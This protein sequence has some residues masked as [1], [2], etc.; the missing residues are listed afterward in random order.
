MDV[1]YWE[2]LSCDAVNYSI[3]CALSVRLR[4]LVIG[5]N[6]FCAFMDETKS[7]SI[8]TSKRTGTRNETSYCLEITSIILLINRIFLLNL[9]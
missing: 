2:V 4:K 5:E 3:T 8:K 6:L 7:G 1:S 9:F